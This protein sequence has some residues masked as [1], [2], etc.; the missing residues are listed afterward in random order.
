MQI[1][2]DGIVIREKNI[3]DEDRLLTL[4][5]K[6]KGV[7]TAYAKGARR[8][9]SPLASSTE[10]LCYSRFVLFQNRGKTS[11]DKADSN[12]VFFGL[13]GDI[14]ALSL[15]AYL[16]QL[17]I[18]LLPEGEGN[19]DVMRLLLNS[20]H[21]LDQKERSP[22]FIKPIFELRML[23]LCGFMPDLVACRQC[24][25]YESDPMY[26]FPRSGSICCANCLLTAEAGAM[27]LSPSL[28]AALRHIIYADFTKLFA[29][30]L[31]EE[32]LRALSV[33]TQAYLD[34]QLERSFPALAFY[35]SVRG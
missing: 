27:A 3:G 34:A 26:F 28:L 15:A 2:T 21:M 33:A 18:E 1:T 19:P 35:E 32:G 8:P 5:T 25:C 16:A 29:F 30:R 11:V 13:R 23:T 7:L 6:E 9:K 12:R 31:P 22:A 4:L 10:F 20:L 14:E 24:A 17:C